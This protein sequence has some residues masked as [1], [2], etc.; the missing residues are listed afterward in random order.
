MSLIGI[1]GT[2]LEG[3]LQAEWA[4]IQR[5]ALTQVKNVFLKARKNSAI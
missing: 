3:R 2:L 1:A 4:T 5:A